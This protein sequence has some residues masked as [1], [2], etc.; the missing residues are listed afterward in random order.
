MA[1][2]CGDPTY[3][4]GANAGDVNSGTDLATTVA[5]LCIK[6]TIAVKVAA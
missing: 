4:M 1:Q 3:L 6:Q 2:I 5:K